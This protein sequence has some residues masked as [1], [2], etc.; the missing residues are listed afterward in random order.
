MIL[1]GRIARTHG[2]RGHVLVAPDTDFAEERFAPG[3]TLFT[4]SAHGEETLVVASMRMQNGRPL[5]GFRGFDDIDTVERIVGQELRVPPEA[6]A[7]L[8]ANTYYHHDL[9]GCAVETAA[10][11]PVGAVIGVQGGAGGSL[12]VV[13]G[14]RGEILVP[15]ARDICIDV[16]VQAKRIRIQ[17]PEGLLELNEKVRSRQ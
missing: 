1:V 13:N 15:L 5:I 10:G 17:P 16:D 9:V 7:P 14:A 3:A 12:L 11:E 6:L 8:D 2:I 4:R